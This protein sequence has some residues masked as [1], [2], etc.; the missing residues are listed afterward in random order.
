MMNVGDGMMGLFGMV[1]FMLV[2]LAPIV[3]VIWAIV[4][5]VRALNRVAAAQESATRA[6]EQISGYLARKV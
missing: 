6:L 5:V 4:N 1:V 3:L 2:Y